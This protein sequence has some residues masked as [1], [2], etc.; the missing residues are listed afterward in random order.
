MVTEI[1]WV[2]SNVAA[3]SDQQI[4]A[5]VQDEQIRLKIIEFMQS[6]DLTIKREATYIIT[7]IL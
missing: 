2:Y 1:L 4:F 6:N 3:G 5:L 7:N